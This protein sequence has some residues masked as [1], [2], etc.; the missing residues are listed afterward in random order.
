MSSNN[1]KYNIY[2]SVFTD[3]FK[4]AMNQLRL[5]RE[6]HPEDTDVTVND[7]TN[8]TLKPVLTDQLYNDLGF[9]VKDR[10]IMLVEAQSKWCPNMTLRTMLYL[11]ESFKE[12][13]LS[14]GQNYYNAKTVLLPKPELY[15]IYTGERE[16]SEDSMSMAETFWDGDD[17]FMEVKVKMLHADDPNTI[18]TQYAGFSD[19]YRKY[20]MKHGA[21][22]EA[23]IATIDECIE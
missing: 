15:V 18:V 6:L 10:T 14:T 2:D 22:R 7:I 9:M 1:A 17:S 5:Y 21:T 20:K 13:I 16:H 4:D 11:A 23:V 3:L 19:I 12:Y 8:V